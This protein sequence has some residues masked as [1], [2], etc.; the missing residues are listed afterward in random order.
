MEKADAKAVND[1]L[2]RLKLFGGIFG[3]I[4]P[5][6]LASLDGWNWSSEVIPE[7]LVLAR[8]AGPVPLLP[9][10]QT[11]TAREKGWL[12]TLAVI[13]SDPDSELIFNSDNWSFRASPR[14]LNMI[15][16][17][18]PNNTNIFNNVYNPATPLGPLYGLAWFPVKFWPYKTQITFQAQHPA[19]A[20]TPTSQVVAA[21][22]GRMYIRDSKQYYESIFIESQ[23][24]AI[25]T[26]KVPIRRGG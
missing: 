26:V 13:F 20:L 12:M 11:S 1:I 6:A 18:V 7:R 22:L 5:E 4:V 14:L 10:I 15:G 3:P 21:A 19:T 9:A 2:D 17:T 8:G 23:R 25:G 24:Q 16:G